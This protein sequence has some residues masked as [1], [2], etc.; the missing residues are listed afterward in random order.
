[1]ELIAFTP[2]A[3]LLLVA[4]AVEHRLDEDD[5]CTLLRRL[6]ADHAHGVI[7]VRAVERHVAAVVADRAA[8]AALDTFAPVLLDA[9]A[10]D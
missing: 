5:A 9:V 6:R 10:A 7:P 1:M 4:L 8:F 2:A 3:A